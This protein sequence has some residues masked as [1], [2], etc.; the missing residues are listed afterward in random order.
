MTAPRSPADTAEQARTASL[1][2]R[3]LIARCL[4]EELVMIEIN[5]RWEQARTGGARLHGD[6]AKGTARVQ[7]AGAQ[8]VQ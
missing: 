5:S 6:G 1:F 2:E 4:G 8:P 3:S 7:R